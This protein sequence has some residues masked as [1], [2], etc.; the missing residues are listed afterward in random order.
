M[1]QQPEAAKFIKTKNKK[2]PTLTST[3]KHFPSPLDVSSAIQLVSPTNFV[4]H[5]KSCSPKLKKNDFEEC[6]SKVVPYNG[7]KTNHID[8]KSDEL[9]HQNKIKKEDELETE[10]S[11]DES[12]D[13]STYS[14]SSEESDNLPSLN[15]GCVSPTVQQGKNDKLLQNS[16]LDKSI[17]TQ[18]S[19]QE[20]KSE[21]SIQVS[22]KSA[23]QDYNASQISQQTSSIKN[24]SQKSFKD[25]TFGKVKSKEM[26]SFHTSTA[27]LP[28]TNV[29]TFTLPRSIS[30]QDRSKSNF[31]LPRTERCVRFEEIPNVKNIVEFQPYDM[32]R[33]ISSTGISKSMPSLNSPTEQKL[34]TSMSE[35][36]SPSHVEYT[37]IQHSYT[38]SPVH[39]VSSSAQ[40]IP[41]HIH[42]ELYGVSSQSV[43]PP[44]NIPHLFH[45]Q[46][47]VVPIISNGIAYIPVQMSSPPATTYFPPNSFPTFSPK[48]LHGEKLNYTNYPSQF[49]FPTEN[50]PA[51]R[52]LVTPANISKGESPSTEPPNV[53]SSP[54]IASADR[55]KTNF[56]SI[57]PIP[58]SSSL[59]TSKQ[60]HTYQQQSL[61]K[62]Q[63]LNMIDSVVKGPKIDFP[64]RENNVPEFQHISLR[65]AN[66]LPRDNSVIL[67]DQTESIPKTS[68]LLSKTIS[69][70]YEDIN[71]TTLENLPIYEKTYSIPQLMLS[72][73]INKQSQSPPVSRLNISTPSKDHQNASLL[74]STTATMAQSIPSPFIPSMFSSELE[75]KYMSNYQSVYPNPSRL[76]QETTENAQD[77]NTQL[78]AGKKYLPGTPR[79]LSESFAS[80]SFPESSARLEFLNR[81]LETLKLDITSPL[82]V[83]K[84]KSS[85]SLKKGDIEYSGKQSPTT[86][87]LPP[88]NYS[89]LPTQVTS[90]SWMEI[91]EATPPLLERYGL[92]TSQFSFSKVSVSSICLIKNII[93]VLWQATIILWKCQS[94]NLKQI[95][96]VYSN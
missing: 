5:E 64:Q 81:S 63:F 26:S 71:Q 60:D 48:H 75:Q 52:R 86:P 96:Q 19:K 17:V 85:S 47:P 80:K 23:Q 16:Y 61:P 59:M 31:T 49:S 69:K 57:Q 41:S 13:D 78:R 84:E 82:Q 92:Q 45:G 77:S 2:V 7:E 43:Q 89:T 90:P 56:P 54:T 21:L 1:H 34:L 91:F 66:Y 28:T 58:S 10:S 76:D 55:F 38:Q 50:Q 83:E 73:N 74:A 37:N 9:Q 27:E 51:N 93:I 18:N 15:V 12:S 88:V 46:A 30:K 20:Y 70:T 6:S 40:M 3:P 44:G 94:K 39:T 29:F 24:S 87:T 4:K 62:Y 11:S 95:I 65:E 79:P 68:E 53:G 14:D 8:N 35:I 72:A 36:P 42:G 22:P 33:P 67:I 25:T 32:H